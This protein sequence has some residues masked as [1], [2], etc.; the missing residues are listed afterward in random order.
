MQLRSGKIYKT[1]LHNPNEI[2]KERYEEVLKNNF[3]L[4]KNTIN[5]KI[6]EKYNMSC[7]DI[8]DLPYYDYFVEGVTVRHVIEYIENEFFY[9]NDI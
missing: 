2:S 6:I 7:E 4:W 3:N 9:I 8:P 5:N 1:Q